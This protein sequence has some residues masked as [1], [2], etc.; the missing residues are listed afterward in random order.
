MPTV[1]GHYHSHIYRKRED[2]NHTVQEDNNTI[3][4]I[5]LAR[6][7]GKKRIIGGD[8]CRAARSGNSTVRVL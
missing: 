5:L 1:V 3:V 6:A 7:L 8:P 2:L 4:Q